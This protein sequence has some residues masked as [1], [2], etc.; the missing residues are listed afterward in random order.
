MAASDKETIEG[1]QKKLMIVRHELEDVKQKYGALKRNYESVSHYA[2]KDN[3]EFKKMKTMRDG[4][5]EHI[6]T[7]MA[8]QRKSAES[9]KVLLE[10]LT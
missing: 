10:D 9:L 1:Q 5:E 3:A 4:F 2:A 8:S 6:A 7:L